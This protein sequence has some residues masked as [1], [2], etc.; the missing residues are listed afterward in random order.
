MSNGAERIRMELMV[1]FVRRFFDG[2]LNKGIDR[3]P[4]RMR[5]KA[6]SSSRCCIYHDRVVLRYRLMAL[7][8]LAYET[9]TD[10]T[11]P[12]STYL[13]EAGERGRPELPL[14]VCGAACD[15]CP[16][17]GY[18]V[19]GNCRGCFARPCEY[20]C[21]K[22][23]ISVVNGR[24]IIDE[25]KC[26]NCGK[27]AKVCPYQA[28]TRIRVPCEEACPVGAIKK[29]ANGVAE[30]DFDKCIY[31]G[32]CVTNCPFAAV[33]ERSELHRILS[34]IASGEK[35]VAIVAPSA[36]MQ[37]PGTLAQ[38]FTAIA[39]AGFSDV[40]EVAI[41]AERTM[42][43]EAHEFIERMEAGAKLMTTSC[44]PAWTELVKKHLPAFMPNVS[45]T[46]SPM[47]YAAAI[48][49]KAHPGAKIVFVGPCIAK[50]KEAA[51][52][53]GV[54]FVMTFQELGALL[55]GRAIDVVTQEDWKFETQA[56]AQARNFAKNCGVTEAVLHQMCGSDSGSTLK[57]E[58]G[59][60][61]GIDRKTLPLLK[62]HAAGK[63]Q[64]NFLEVMGCEGGCASGPCS[65]AK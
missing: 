12:L 39:K 10:E 2:T 30:I 41:G 17:G 15:G 47:V 29:N 35:I 19:T 31:C 52:I 8:G 50:R 65:I 3:I 46:P 11:I 26:I 44:C 4:M 34:C 59:F 6:T 13:A 28:I 27:C 63:L 45:E 62:I 43:A 21:P 48:A 38:L 51:E 33:M 25:S 58:A 40:I 53:E 22:D 20:A 49:Q 36:E 60:I 5:P 23:A 9:E 54:D 56:C 14:T 1:R 61:N 64:K 57:L 16:D 55:A 37:F 7:L 32:K 24:S 42:E 18:T